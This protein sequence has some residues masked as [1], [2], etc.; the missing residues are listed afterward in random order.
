[1]LAARD[2]E[3][4]DQLV[5]ELRISGTEALA[6]PTDVGIRNEVE[7]LGK[8]AIGRFGRIDSW[9]NNAGISI[10][11]RNADVPLK[12]QEKLFQTNFWGVVHGS[13]VALELMKKMAVRLLTSAVSC[14]T[15]RSRYRV[16]IQPPNMRSR[17]SPTR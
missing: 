8:A 15:Y 6:V 11:G 3:A 16:C 14:P 4:L 2:S 7:A 12:D 10:F 17:G 1:V 5:E 13:L 9:I